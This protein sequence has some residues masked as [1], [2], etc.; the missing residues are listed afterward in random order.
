MASLKKFD[1]ICKSKEVTSINVD[2]AV[3]AWASVEYLKGLLDAQTYLQ[4]HFDEYLSVMSSKLEVIEKVGMLQSLPIVFSFRRK[5]SIY[6]SG[7]FLVALFPIIGLS[8]LGSVYFASLPTIDPITL[9]PVNNLY[10][11]LTAILFG[12]Y[13]LTF[14]VLWIGYT[15]N[16]ISRSRF[17]YL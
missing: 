6:V 5:A 16:V 15:Q 1:T 11:V 4:E 17:A 2:Y 14:V 8:L 3:R 13:I 7:K 10:S 9:E 12:L